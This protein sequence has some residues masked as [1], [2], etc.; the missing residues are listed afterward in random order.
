MRITKNQTT[1]KTLADLIRAADH[2]FAVTLTYVDD[3]GDE[4]IRTIEIHE[5]RTTADGDVILVAM[6]RL[7][8]DERNFRVSKVTA[9]TVHRMAYV[10]ER[11]AP[12]AYERPAPAPADDARALFFYELA[13][14]ADDAD[15]QPRRKLAQTDT[16]LAA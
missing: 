8:G 2:R 9:Y 12:T 14:D 4:T 16:G 1:T 5:L 11:P 13:R 7:R 10:L 6:C 3:K 15:H